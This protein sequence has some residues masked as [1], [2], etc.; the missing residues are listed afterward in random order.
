MKVS[1]LA[2]ALMAAYSASHAAD[3]LTAYREALANDPSYAAARAQRDADQEKRTQAK[4]GL[5]PQVGLQASTNWNQADVT[6]AGGA[7]Q[8]SRDYNSNAYGIQL[9]QPLFRWQSWVQYE[10]GDLAA[11]MADTQLSLTRQ[12]LTLRVAQAYFQVL[13]AQDALD[14]VTYLRRA[15][16]EQNRAAKASFEKGVVTVTDVHEA[17]ARLD[18][19]QA[20]ELTAQQ[21]LGLARAN[22]TRLT[23]Q[24]VASVAKLPVAVKLAP[25]HPIAADEWLAAAG[26]NNLGVHLR[27]MAQDMSALAAR[28]AAAGHLPTL[29]L[30]AS[31]GVQ[32]RT[33]MGVD[34]VEANTVGVQFTLPLYAGGYISSQQREAALLRVKA[35]A[36][37]D[38]ARKGAQLA[39]QQAW[40]NLTSGLAQVKAL[41]ASQQSSQTALDSNKL[42][43]QVGVRINIDVLNAQAQLAD[44]MQRLSKA[45][46]DTLMAQL[47]LKAAVGALSDADVQQLNALLVD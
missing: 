45:R 10:Q 19:A 38:D 8:L 11:A 32:N 28:R 9:T 24:P 44:T 40:L 41:E 31:R 4:A 6:M 39:A 12:D 5:L 37:L 36:E 18:L 26:Q 17:Q 15:S 20:Q 22:L 43:Y 23:G 1:A 34:R 21:Q 29:D 14:A 2:V 16:D 33:T 35:E 7:S 13:Y 27:E 46:Y 42:G 30:V 47:Q 25:P 3:L